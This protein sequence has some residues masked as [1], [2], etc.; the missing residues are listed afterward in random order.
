MSGTA[1]KL[2]RFASGVVWR[3]AS[4]C[5][6]VVLLMQSGGCSRSHYRTHADE[7]ALSILDE[8]TQEPQWTPPLSYSI[9]PSPQSRLFDP[10]PIEDPILPDARPRLHVYEIPDGIGRRSTSSAATPPPG[11][12]AATTS[13]R[14][15]SRLV[16]RSAGRQV[17]RSAGRQVGRSAG[18]QVGRSAAEKILL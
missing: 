7:D 3:I 1:R 4:P 2:F 12:T 8:K 16:G 5:L 11:E 13:V 18:R 17:G 6:A 9:E 15:A 14:H 10:S